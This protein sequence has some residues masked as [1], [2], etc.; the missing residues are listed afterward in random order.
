M[1]NTDRFSTI[2][3]STL[4]GMGWNKINYPRHLRAFNLIFNSKSSYIMLS[5]FC[6]WGERRLLIK[7]HLIDTAK[8]TMHTLVTI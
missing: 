7:S 6:V 2:V 4:V 5:V 3:G 8:Y 1:L